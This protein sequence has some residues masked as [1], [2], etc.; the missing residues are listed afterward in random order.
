MAL[1]TPDF[2]AHDDAQ[3]AFP[4]VDLKGQ[5]VLSHGGLARLAGECGRVRRHGSKALVLGAGDRALATLGCA[6]CSADQR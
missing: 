4:A 6:N 2:M 1:A 3:P 5:T